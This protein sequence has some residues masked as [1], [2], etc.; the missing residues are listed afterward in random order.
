MTRERTLALESGIGELT[1]AELADG[2]HFCIEF[3]EG[4]INAQELAVDS[5]W[6][7]PFC[8]HETPVQP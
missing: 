6:Y 7:C 3:D 8:G 2:Y 1:P 5:V 4:C